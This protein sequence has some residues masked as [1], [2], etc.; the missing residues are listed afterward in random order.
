M[1]NREEGYII[2]DSKYYENQKVFG[3]E[4]LFSNPFEPHSVVGFF[5]K[6]FNDNGNRIIV[7]KS[8]KSD[9][10][11]NN[12][13]NR[14]ILK[15]PQ[16]YNLILTTHE[17]S[18]KYTMKKYKE[19]QRLIKVSYNSKTPLPYI[20]FASFFEGIDV[21][22][23]IKTY[24]QTK[25]YYFSKRIINRIKFLFSILFCDLITA[26][27]YQRRISKLETELESIDY[28]L[29]LADFEF[30]TNKKDIELERKQKQKEIDKLI[31]EK[32][33]S[34][35]SISTVMLTI[36]SLV[37]LYKQVTISKKQ[38]LIQTKQFQMEDA[39]NQ[40]KFNI[41]LNVDSSLINESLHIKKIN[42][43]YI[44]NVNY[45][46]EVLCFVNTQSG[47]DIF[48]VR[49]FY[50]NVIY[51]PIN[52]AEEF[53]FERKDNL[54]RFQ[55]LQA[56]MNQTQ[57]QCDLRRYIK[58]SYND[59]LDTSHEKYFWIV[60]LYGLR[61]GDYTNYFKLEYKELSLQEIIDYY[62]PKILNADKSIQ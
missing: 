1:R 23:K 35:R 28:R 53:I 45:E 32:N 4:Y 41:F 46:I 16:K 31:Q 40:P 56:F 33:I 3:L 13:Q 62:T 47:I 26:H 58:I 43:A 29:F 52:V 50:N 37:I 10:I 20:A 7:L 2:M 39:L 6:E 34:F 14:L 15:Q 27:N 48:K 60:P 49:D 54:L 9:T 5:F 11:R 21:L 61:T 12:I 8:N 44:S 25:I 42:D 24:K 57:K 22:S 38:T 19:L 30:N 36:L 59:Y 51:S 18:E 55:K 17:L